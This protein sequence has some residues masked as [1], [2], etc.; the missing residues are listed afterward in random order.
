MIP[1]NCD[2]DDD[3]ADKI[4]RQ[5]PGVRGVDGVVRQSLKTSELIQQNPS[6]GGVF[7][8]LAKNELLVLCELVD[9]KD[10]DSST[11]GN[12]SQLI[13]QRK[14]TLKTSSPKDQI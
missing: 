4:V 6:L 9:T 14:P 10:W 13:A 7:K 3:P 12:S 1:V 5:T 2:D 8:R 11:L